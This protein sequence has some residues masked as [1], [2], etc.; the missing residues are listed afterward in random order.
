MIQKFDSRFSEGRSIEMKGNLDPG[1]PT[2]GFNVELIK[3][4]RAPYGF[5]R[6]TVLPFRKPLLPFQ[7]WTSVAQ[8]GY[9]KKIFFGIAFPSRTPATTVGAIP[10]FLLMATYMR[11]REA[12]V[13]RGTV[14]AFEHLV[15]FPIQPVAVRFLTPKNTRTF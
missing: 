1:I 12:D 5:L 3:I 7:I 15:L 6:P 14:D 11:I 13:V 4:L 10:S 9:R 2:E 8:P